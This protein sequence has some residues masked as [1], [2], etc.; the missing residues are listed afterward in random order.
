M[1]ALNDWELHE[2]LMNRDQ[3]ADSLFARA[4]MEKCMSPE[5]AKKLKDHV[6][7][8]TGRIPADAVVKEIMDLLQQIPKEKN[9]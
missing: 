1:E 2:I 3:M 7:I 6:R 8:E 5:D 4:V 9:S